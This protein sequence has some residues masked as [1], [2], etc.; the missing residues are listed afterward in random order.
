[1]KLSLI[2]ATIAL[3]STAL[4]APAGSPEVKRR[5]A[6]ARDTADMKREAYRPDWRREAMSGVAADW[7]REPEAM[8]GVAAD[9][10]GE[11]EAMSGVAAD[12]R[13]DPE[14]ILIG[15]RGRLET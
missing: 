5:E 7:R 11:P 15:S 4:A 12:W 2:F 13:R 6:E 8:S 14:A 10:R 9:W 3:A 1:M